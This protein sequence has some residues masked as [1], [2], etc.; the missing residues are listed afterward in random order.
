VRVVSG[1]SGFMKIT[2]GKRARKENR[3]QIVEG[4]SL[5]LCL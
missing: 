3:S 5:I 4:V 2:A 1:D